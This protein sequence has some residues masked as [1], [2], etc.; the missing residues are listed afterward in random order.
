VSEAPL[1]QCADEITLTEDKIPSSDSFTAKPP[2][3]LMGSGVNT[4]AGFRGHRKVSLSR[5]PVVAQNSTSSTTEGPVY[6]Q[7]TRSLDTSVTTPLDLGV[8]GNSS[9]R[10]WPL[11][12]SHNGQ[13]LSVVSNF[14][15]ISPQQGSGNLLL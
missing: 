9:K 11:S 5:S 13:F 7:V 8:Q 1:K 3:Q 2:S 12:S 14:T 10:F 15:G 4:S 6:R